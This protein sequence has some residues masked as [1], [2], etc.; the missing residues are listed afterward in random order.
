VFHDLTLLIV[1]KGHRKQPQIGGVPQSSRPEFSDLS[2]NTPHKVGE[3]KGKNPTA[4]SQFWAK[5]DFGPW[6]T[7]ISA[8]NIRY[9]FGGT[10]KARQPLLDRSSQN[11]QLVCIKST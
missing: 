11:S 5:I 2:G 9:S 4:N 3:E 10:P 6:P 1:A 7:D 8:L